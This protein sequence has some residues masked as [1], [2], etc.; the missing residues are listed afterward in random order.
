MYELFEMSERYINVI[1][2]TLEPAAMKVYLLY[3]PETKMK[4]RN[5][6]KRAQ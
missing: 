5:C 1:R 3:Y 2:N 4:T 6:A